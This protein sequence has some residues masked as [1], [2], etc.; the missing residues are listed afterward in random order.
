MRPN[1]WMMKS[2]GQDRIEMAKDFSNEN[3][4]NNVLNIFNAK[5]IKESNESDKNNFC[6]ALEVVELSLINALNNDNKSDIKE[7]AELA[8]KLY[9]S[10]ELPFDQIERTRM[11]LKIT[12]YGVI[13]E[14]N[15]DVRNWL[16]KVG[17]PTIPIGNINWSNKVFLDTSRAFL[18]TVRK[19][20]W[21]DLEETIDTIKNLREYQ[22]QFE[23]KYLSNS[24]HPNFDIL[25]LIALY[26]L[27]KAVELLALFFK[28]GSSPRKAYEDIDF[29]LDKSLEAINDA[30]IID[31]GIIVTWVQYA[32]R[33][34]V[35]N[36]IWWMIGGNDNVNKFI[37]S[38][39]S[40][41][42]HKP[43]FE[44]WPP[45]SKALLEQGLLDPAKRAVVISMPTS[46]GKTLLAEFRIIWT[47]Q[48]MPDS[49]IAYIVPTRSLVNQ[50]TNRLRKDLQ[51]L[52]IKVEKAVP[53]FELDPIEEQLLISPD[54]FNILVTTQEKLDLLIRNERF[55]DKQKPLGLVIL[56]EAHNINDKERGLKIEM[57]LSTINR[58]YNDV[59]FLL[60]SP[61]VPNVEDLANWLDSERSA[62]ISI[63]WR[64]NEQIVGII[65]PEGEKRDWKLKVNTIYT[66]Q[67]TILLKEKI[68][69]NDNTLNKTISS[70]SKNDIASVAAYSLSKRNGVIIIVLRKDYATTIAEQLYDL[71]PEQSVPEE[72]RLVQ[73]YIESEFGRDYKLY[74]L[75]DKGV[76]FHHAGVTHELR[77][78]LEWLMEKGLIKIMVATTTLSQGVN[79]PISS[80]IINDFKTDIPKQPMST[81]KFWNIAGRAGRANQD[82][83]GVI[84]FTSK[85]ED[86]KE[87]KEFVN[88]KVSDLM[89][90]FE[91]IVKDAI[92]NG[93]ELDFNILV[94]NNPEWSNFI[95]YLCHSYRQ[96]GDYNKF[97][98]ESEKI[99]KATY[100]YQR[101]NKEYP[102][103]AK[104]IIH[105]TID[106]AT[107]IKNMDKQVLYLVDQTGFSPDSIKT[108]RSGL[109]E[110]KLSVTDWSTKTLFNTKN[111]N[112]KDIMGNLLNISEL[113]IETEKGKIEGDTL[114]VII[115]KWVN[116]EKI[117]EIA[118]LPDFKS[119]K[120]DATEAVN[121][122]VITLNRLIM[123]TS[124]GIAALEGLNIKKDDLEKL[125]KKTQ[126][127]IRSI[128]AMIYFGTDTIEGV[129]MRNLGIPRSIANS[130]GQSYIK[131]TNEQIPS[132]EKM[133]TWLKSGDLK[134]WTKSVPK[135]NIMNGKEY[136]DIWKIFNGEL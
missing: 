14:R 113:D 53:A 56:D 29:H 108:M 11:L 115:S 22:A 52:G 68:E 120:E 118:K 89:S 32:S 59:Q 114:A 17:I 1:D 124:W 33:L 121:D 55:Q 9:R 84:L 31:L 111:H 40:E 66:S 80:I 6:R 95:Q 34:M 99:I 24:E 130:L 50:I 49:W 21:K 63:K 19:N 132:I 72:V 8:F 45:Q 127:E 38:L 97:I 78:L 126:Y 112:L 25:E 64:P 93:N 61:F 131:E 54:S 110:I 92:N 10:I 125:D 2:F 109:R 88:K 67:P 4:C 75:L 76:A 77:Y 16:R 3:F 58:E 119:K 74:K 36:S 5:I 86:D 42:S 23:E 94:K 117:S 41:N 30:R 44:L 60:L 7:Y 82:D 83:L 46:S 87:I 12:C 135:N 116:G 79:F 51:P 85:T 133:R 104:A 106:Y 98:S 136:Q 81:D 128:P 20:N 134:I 91:K 26:H 27:A 47:I 18:L 96:I 123:N 35:K 48:N 62:K 101:I 103:I 71:L 13:G 37:K 70:L 102:A 90:Y 69:F 122:C 28:E 15:A 100:G 73:K 107:E 39:A 65:Y 43:I 105:S 57:L 129:A